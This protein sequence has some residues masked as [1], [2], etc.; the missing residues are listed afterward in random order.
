MEN[1][2]QQQ[3]REQTSRVDGRRGRGWFHGRHERLVLIDVATIN[4]LP[5]FV[6]HH[7]GGD[8]FGLTTIL[9]WA[10][11]G[12]RGDQS[13]PFKCELRDPARL[14]IKVPQVRRLVQSGFAQHSG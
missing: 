6:H 11:A 13:M 2:R 1:S 14:R 4:L 12:S 7:M 5:M 8:N 10:H 9:S 3:R